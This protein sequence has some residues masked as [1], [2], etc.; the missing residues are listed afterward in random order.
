MQTLIVFQQ[1]EDIEFQSEAFGQFISVLLNWSVQERKK[2]TKNKARQ[3]LM[4]LQYLPTP[5]L[6][7]SNQ[8]IVI[9]I[10]LFVF[11]LNNLMATKIQ[12]KYTLG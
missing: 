8:I 1:R 11:C 9:I 2:K 5:S 6:T 3:N 4:L 10:Y 7:K 12:N